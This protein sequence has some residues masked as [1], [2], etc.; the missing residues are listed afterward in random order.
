MKEPDKQLGRRTVFIYM[1]SVAAMIFGYIFWI[2][3]SR[4]ETI[5][6]VGTLSAMGSLAGIFSAISS[7]GIPEGIQRFLSKFFHEQ[8]LSDAKVFVN[9][10]IFMVSAGTALCTVLILI[11]REW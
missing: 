7:F 3:L 10:S 8:K 9:S 2:I 5:E 6:I 11:M 1:E 4:F